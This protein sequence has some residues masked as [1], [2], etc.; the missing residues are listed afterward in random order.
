MGPAQ[1]RL[2]VVL[3]QLG[4]RQPV[5]RMR[6][7]IRAPV[8][9]RSQRADRSSRLTGTKGCFREPCSAS[10]VV[11]APGQGCFELERRFR[12]VSE[13]KK[14]SSPQ[15]E[16]GEVSPGAPKRLVE[17]GDSANGLVPPQVDTAQLH[18]RGRRSRLEL[19]GTAKRLLCFLPPSLIR[20]AKAQGE[21]L[22][23]ALGRRTGLQERHQQEEGYRHSWPASLCGLCLERHDTPPAPTHS[24]GE[25]RLTRRRPRRG[26]TAP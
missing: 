20:Q 11:G 21:Q 12:I 23:E 9:H 18:V 26:A 25:N 8:D 5:E 22:L 17:R 4:E 16:G 3:P 13:L 6:H 14:C 7:P 15:V 24:I 10:L 1:Y 2:I 19:R